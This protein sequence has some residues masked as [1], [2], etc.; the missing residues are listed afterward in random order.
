MTKPWPTASNRSANTAPKPLARVRIHDINE[1]LGLSLP[2]DEDYDTIGG[3]VFHE[4]G[5]IPNIGEELACARR[6]DQGPGSDA[7]PDSPRRNPRCRPPA[8]A[9]YI[10]CEPAV[11]PRPP[12]AVSPSHATKEAIFPGA[13]TTLRSKPMQRTSVKTARDPASV[14]REV[15]MQGWIRTRRDSKG[16]FS[17]GTE[18]RLV[19]GQSANCRRWEVAELRQ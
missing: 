15:R 5:R 16:G 14:G 18:R 9:D 6:A 10:I 3:F 1:R 13:F 7:P 12:L 8:A 4:L 2:E 19:A 11:G 17:F